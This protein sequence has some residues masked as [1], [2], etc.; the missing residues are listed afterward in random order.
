MKGV[1]WTKFDMAFL[2]D[3]SFISAASLRLQYDRKFN[4]SRLLGRITHLCR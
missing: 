2:L 4:K 3:G 1:T